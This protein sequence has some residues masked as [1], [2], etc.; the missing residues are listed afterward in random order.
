MLLL[1]TML[2]AAAQDSDAV[3]RA[4]ARY[5]ELTRADVPCAAPDENEEIVV[6]AARDA[7][8]YRVPFLTVARGD[9]RRE[10]V[11]EE[12]ERY[13]RTNTPCQDN[14]PFLIGCGMVGVSMTVTQGGGT[15]F[16]TER[17]L[18]P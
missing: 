16:E 9:P 18:A 17:E 1:S 15:R 12:R 4:V 11:H 10:G 6:C 5:H 8:N 13:I 7:D 3:N 14:G 2:F